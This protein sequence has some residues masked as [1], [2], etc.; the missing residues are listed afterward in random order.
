MEGKDIFKINAYD[1]INSAAIAR[2]CQEIDHQ[3]TPLQVAYLIH[4]S[5]KH[6]L[7]EKHQ[8]FQW[9]IEN[10]PDDEIRFQTDAVKGN[11]SGKASLKWF[12]KKYMAL[13]NKCLDE[14]FMADKDSIYQSGVYDSLPEFYH[15]GGR[16]Q[17]RYYQTVETALLDIERDIVN[18]GSEEFINICKNYINDKQR[19][20]SILFNSGGEVTDIYN[21]SGMS[22]EEMDIMDA[23]DQVCFACPV[24]FKKGDIVRAPFHADG[25]PF[26]F[27]SL[28]YEGRSEEDRKKYINHNGSMDMLAY[29]Y[30]Q[31]DGGRIY[32]ESMHDYLSIE[33]YDGSFDG[34]KRVLRAVSNFL[35]GELDLADVLNAYHIIM[36]EENANEIRKRLM[37]TSEGMRLAGLLEEENEKAIP[38]KG[39]SNSVYESEC[40]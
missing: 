29:G 1:F 40:R 26:V 17:G 37:L 28:W 18:S 2:H 33:Y 3:F 20:I 10:M 25:G 16:E 11:C 32:W 5:R 21:D 19:C 22:Y 34:N 27:L 35:K 31:E 13:Q 36:N 8:A 14:F 7:K 23:F 30:F 9:V 4:G 38:S 15:H 24:P 6:T 12:L 39:K